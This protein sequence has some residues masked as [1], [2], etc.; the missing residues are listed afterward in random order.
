MND[1]LALSD[2]LVA[3]AMRTEKLARVWQQGL[4]DMQY[5]ESVATLVRLR[6]T[7]GDFWVELQSR[8]EAGLAASGKQC[9]T[10][11]GWGRWDDIECP[12]CKGVGHHNDF[13]VV[14]RARFARMMERGNES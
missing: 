12:D 13:E 4:N 7:F 8:Q 10:C 11:D 6:A 1:L 9:K 14:E 2:A 5:R 3:Q